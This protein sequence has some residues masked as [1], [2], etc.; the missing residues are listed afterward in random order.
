MLISHEVP[1]DLL[2]LS[3]TFNDY[4]YCLPHY[5]VKYPQYKKFFDNY[6]NKNNSFIILDNGLFEG[7]VLPE[8][9]LLDII[10]G[11]KPDI[12]IVPDS[13]ND[14]ITTIGYAKEWLKKSIPISTNLMMVL[15]GKS[16]DQLHECSIQGLK[17]GYKYF[18]L[19]HSSLAYSDVFYHPNPII[20]KM[21]GRIITLNKLV[22][23]D[24]YDKF[25]KCYIHLLGMISPEEIQLINHKNII[26]SIDTS[27][28]VLNGIKGLRYSN[29]SFP[30]GKP[31]EKIEI[32]MEK[33]LAF[34]IE[35]IIFNINQFR[36]M[37]NV[38]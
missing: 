19:N 30:I 5:Y 36:K 4:Q 15:Q 21:M 10:N 17:L 29:L 24:V 20:S 14:Y 25:K 28:P 37:S 3:L 22:E 2:E 7:G 31:E 23:E 38:Y 1:L 9:Q 12:F 35:D 13:W 18:G 6:R 11:L 16:Y 34:N 26:K 33:D 27:N 8:N 32:F